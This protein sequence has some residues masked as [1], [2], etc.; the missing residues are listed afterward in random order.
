MIKIVAYATTD[1]EAPPNARAC[2]WLHASGKRLPMAFFAA[3]AQTA[4]VNA[5]AWWDV[6]RA[7]EAA[8]AERRRTSPRKTSKPDEAADV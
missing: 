7:K 1:P 3:D 4:R 5:A 2:A 8:K 6:E